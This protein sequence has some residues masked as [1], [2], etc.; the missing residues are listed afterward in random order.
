MAEMPKDIP[1]RACKCLNV[2]IWPQLNA[3]SPPDFLMPTAGDSDY[4]LMYVG[5]QGISIVGR[6]ETL[7][8]FF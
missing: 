8:L 2:R 6:T 5:E 3:E 4:A 1:S 7:P